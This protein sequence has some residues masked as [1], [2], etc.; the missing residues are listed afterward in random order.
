MPRGNFD[1]ECRPCIISE[2]GT[3]EKGLTLKCN[4][5]KP[6]GVPQY[7]SIGMG[8]NCKFFMLSKQRILL[9]MVQSII[10]S[11]SRRSPDDSCAVI[12]WAPSRQTSAILENA[13]LGLAKAARIWSFQR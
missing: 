2:D 4:C 3:P 13:S 7:T 11:P 9:T 8:P 1:N 12:R 10:L 6:N 5:K